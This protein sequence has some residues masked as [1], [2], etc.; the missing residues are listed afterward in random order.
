[1]IFMSVTKMRAQEN[2][3]KAMKR[4]KEPNTNNSLVYKMNYCIT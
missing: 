2:G 1:M 4:N 3:D